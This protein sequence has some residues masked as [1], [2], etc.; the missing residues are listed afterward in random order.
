MPPT[1][2]RNRGVEKRSSTL[3]MLASVLVTC[4]AISAPAQTTDLSKLMDE[5]MSDSNQVEYVRS[6]FKTT[7]LVNGHSSEQVAFG[8]MDM[9]VSHRFGTLNS[10]AYNLWGLDNATMRIALEYGATPW[11]T[12]G[13]GRS[14][15]Q[16]TY[17]GFLKL[18]V[19]RQSKGAR[20]MPL[21]LNYLSS[22]AVNGT[23]DNFP[24]FRSRFFFTHQL[25]LSRKFSESF[26]FLVAPT[27]VHRN[28]VLN[29][30]D[31]HDL[32][33][34]GA[35]GRLKITN[36]VSINAEYYYQIN[37]PIGTQDCLSIGVD[38]ETGGHVFQL[39]LSNGMGM[40]EKAFIHETTNT[41]SSGGIM[42]GFCISRNFTLIDARKSRFKNG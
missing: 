12:V 29:S 42:A 38:I 35:G 34:I 25:L 36:R 16:K 8:A 7:R 10:G 1:N 17:D 15:L 20:K 39:T 4:F 22:W 37:K 27:F 26:S 31:D 28:L 21:T 6:A 14:T 33:S 9:R 11:L 23:K 32:F 40:I 13:V 5:V 41:W 18:R 2:L 30:F 24:Y 3:C 19:L